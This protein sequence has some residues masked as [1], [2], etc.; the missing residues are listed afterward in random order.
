MKQPTCIVK[1]CQVPTYT[2]LTFGGNG[3][4]LTAVLM[5]LGI[6]QDQAILMISKFLDCSP[7][8]EALWDR[9]P[10]E[11]LTIFVCAQC[12]SRA[13]FP[14]PAHPGEPVPIISQA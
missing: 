2:V 11:D 7:S 5:K 12:A 10:G 6:E 13:G 1:S 3:Q 14:P 9:E 4:W 8:L